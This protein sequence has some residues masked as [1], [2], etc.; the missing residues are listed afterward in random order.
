MQEAAAVRRAAL[1]AI[2]DVGPDA[3][4]ESLRSRLG[5]ASM[6]PGV[7]TIYTVRALT[8]GA[9]GVA[10]TTD[11]RLLDA[12]AKRAAGVQLIYEGLALT[13]ELAHTEPWVDGKK[14]EGDLAILAADVLVGRGFH[15]LAQ[16]EAADA[17]VAT[18][19]AFGRDQTVR[20]ETGDAALDKTLEADI[21]EL[22]AV[23]G[24]SMT[25]H[26][27][28]PQLR[29]YAAGLVDEAEFPPADAVFPETFAE[30][31]SGM[32]RDGPQGEGVTPSVDR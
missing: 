31:V 9:S 8:D 22:G 14:D 15:L 18:V 32:V 16:T 25:D 12:V 3:L 13:R 17:A 11:G 2:E 23:A 21:L 27:P 26:S 29:E 30:A 10:V 24:A 5:D 1:D 28:T 6:V 7:L 4:E 20:A 19:R